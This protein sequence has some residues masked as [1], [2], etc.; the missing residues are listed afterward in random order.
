MAP[1]PPPPPLVSP[2]L[3]NNVTGAEPNALETVKLNKLGAVGVLMFAVGAL[4]LLYRLAWTL[5]MLYFFSVLSNCCCCGTVKA[6][7]LSGGFVGTWRSVGEAF[8]HS[9]GDIFM[10][11]MTFGAWAPVTSASI[12]MIIVGTLLYQRAIRQ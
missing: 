7:E 1:F 9:S 2:P 3:P 5:Y 4:F 12:I 8:D 10:Q 11:F 6:D